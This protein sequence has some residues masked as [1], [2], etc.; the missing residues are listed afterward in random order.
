MSWVKDK[1]K[2]EAIAASI[3]PAA[4]LTTKDSWFWT[5]LWVLMLIGVTLISVG[6]GTY[7]FLKKMGKKTFLERYATT[8]GP[9]QGYARRMLA[10]S[11]RLLVHEC[12]HVYQAI[13]AALFVPVLGWLPWRRWRAWVGLLPMFLVYIALP[14]PVGICY[15]R[16]RLELDADYTAWK[17]QLANGYTPQ[18]VRDHA[19]ARV[20][21]VSGGQY[22]WAWPRPLVRRGYTKLSE[23]AIAAAA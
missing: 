11:K 7:F 22:G 15:G 19:A 6:I 2:Y 1:K 9:L 10:L 5:A 3:E 14:F 18:Q 23:R 21:K 17:W 12:R 16:Y 20:L 8:I 13:I 4:K